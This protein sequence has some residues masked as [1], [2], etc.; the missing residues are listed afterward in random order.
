MQKYTIVKTALCI[1]FL[2]GT[3]KKYIRLY[4]LA[5][6]LEKRVHRLKCILNTSII[7]KMYTAL[8][9]QNYFV[10]SIFTKTNMNNISL[11]KV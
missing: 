6:I 2:L 3:H 9:S 10:V 5:H 1:H 7:W 8:E 11:L 4:Y